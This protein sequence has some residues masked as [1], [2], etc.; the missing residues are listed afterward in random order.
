[1]TMKSEF[2]HFLLI[3]LFGILCL[4]PASLIHA[5]LGDLRL[6]PDSQ[7]RWV[8]RELVQN[9]MNM[10]IA[11]LDS[12]LSAKAV[13]AFYQDI[14]QNNAVDGSPGSIVEQLR[15]WSIVSTVTD[16]SLFVVQQ[17]A[18]TGEN[19]STGFV[20]WMSLDKTSLSL[21]STLPQPA[22]ST[23]ISFTRSTDFNQSVNNLG[24][25]AGS[26]AGTTTM[27]LNTASVS[28]N[29]EFY[30]SVMQERGWKLVADQFDH[31]KAALIF[32]NRDSNSEIAL[33]EFVDEQGPKT[34]VVTNQ[35]SKG[36][37]Q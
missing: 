1:M 14:W 3:R 36:D 15:E 11:T 13:V 10:Q 37:F 18:G 25:S 35:V 5:D 9:S 34:L 22:G 2:P 32:S 28:S 17:K 21:H 31:S 12:K 20:S 19:Q 23:V 26:A 4:L 8:G 7:L 24:E 29:Y 30:R 27:L 33:S 6:P 16:N